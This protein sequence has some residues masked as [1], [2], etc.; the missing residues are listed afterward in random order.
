MNNPAE[1]S[2]FTCTLCLQPFED[3]A[4]RLPRLLP[5]CGHTFCSQCIINLL[6]NAMPNTPFVCPE[7]KFYLIFYPFN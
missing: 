3:K 6:E 4:E 1:I 2:E 7:D 5:D